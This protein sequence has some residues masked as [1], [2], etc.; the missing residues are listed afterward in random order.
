MSSSGI[1]AYMETECCIYD[2]YI[3]LLKNVPGN[4]YLKILT[5]CNRY[6]YS[7]FT[8]HLRN[9]ILKRI[10]NVSD[11]LLSMKAEMCDF[12]TSIFTSP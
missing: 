4:I 2:K 1:Q 3:N 5:S 8:L 7:N 9:T 6:Y 12:R 11:K 10:N